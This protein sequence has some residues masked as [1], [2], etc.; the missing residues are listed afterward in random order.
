[1]N[2]RREEGWNESK[3]IINRTMEETR[4]GKMREGRSC[5]NLSRGRALTNVVRSRLAILCTVGP[6]CMS[7]KENREGNNKENCNE[8]IEGL[9]ESKEYSSEGKKGERY[10]RKERRIYISVRTHVYIHMHIYKYSECACV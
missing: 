3:E 5:S 2:E 1:M 4:E 10:Q 7:K 6:A 9:K 8:G